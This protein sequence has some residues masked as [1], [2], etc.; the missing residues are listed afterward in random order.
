M[1]DSNRFCPFCWRFIF[2][3]QWHGKIWPAKRVSSAPPDDSNFSYYT[4]IAQFWRSLDRK[5][6]WHAK[7]QWPMTC[8]GGHTF[9]FRSTDLDRP[10]CY[11]YERVWVH[12]I[13]LSI[14]VPLIKTDSIN[15]LEPKLISH[16]LKTTS[17][18]SIAIVDFPHRLQPQLCIIHTNDERKY[19][20]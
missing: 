12:S 20:V 13:T 6:W 16:R 18:P 2:R 7:Q 3:T 19:I 9:S 15:E 17:K 5:K 10:P 4:L 11:E 1:Y 8:K 14:C